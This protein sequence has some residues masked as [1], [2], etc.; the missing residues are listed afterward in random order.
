MAFIYVFAG[1]FHFIKPKLYL[2]IMPR[3]LPKQKQLVYISGLTE[4][5]LGIALC[6]SVSKN[7]AIYGII[8]M[9]FSFLMVHVYMLTEEKA[10]VGLPKWILYLR[11]LLQFGL[12]YWAYYYMKF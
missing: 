11:L 12:M 9:L 5:I 1:V 2:R 10:A 3:Y 6:F 8:I 4:I 7:W